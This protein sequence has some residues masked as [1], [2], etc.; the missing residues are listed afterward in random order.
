MRF[1]HFNTNKLTEINFYWLGRC[2]GTAGQR[3]FLFAAFR[4]WLRES[5]LL[6]PQRH[7]RTT[8]SLRLSHFPG[9]A[10]RSSD[11]LF[12]PESN[13]RRRWSLVSSGI[14]RR[15]VATISVWN[16]R[17]A[18]GRS[19]LQQIRTLS[20]F[21]GRQLGIRRQTFHPS[22]G[23]QSTRKIRPRPFGGLHHQNRRQTNRWITQN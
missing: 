19:P 8:G 1:F 4:P 11:Q 2:R 12:G 15:T 10:T 16:F 5:P 6:G 20:A 18:I 23:V 14:R 17:H 22:F 7:W 3:V 21:A 9:S 13:G